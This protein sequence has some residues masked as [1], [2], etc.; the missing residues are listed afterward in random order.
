MRAGIVASDVADEAAGRALSLTMGGDT[1]LR[2]LLT[3]GGLRTSDNAASVDSLIDEARG[4]AVRVLDRCRASGSA[5]VVEMAM[6][7]SSWHA[8]ASELIR[9]IGPEARQVLMSGH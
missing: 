5:G 8:L 4:V 2:A 3:D 9:M 1:F 7:R 6:L